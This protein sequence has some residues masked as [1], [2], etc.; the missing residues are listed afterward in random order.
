MI[1]SPQ[2]FENTYRS[3]LDDLIKLQINSKFNLSDLNASSIFY[4][5]LSNELASSG[6]SFPMEYLANLNNQFALCRFNGGANSGTNGSQL[7][8]M[9]N[10]NGLKNDKSFFINQMLDTK[11]GLNKTNSLIKM[12]DIESSNKQFLNNCNN[13]NN[14]NESIPCKHKIELIYLRRNVYKFLNNLMPYLTL[15]S[16]LDINLIDNSTQIDQMIDSLVNQFNNN[17]I[18]SSQWAI[19]LLIFSF[20]IFSIFIKSQ[21]KIFA[22]DSFNSTHCI[23]SKKFKN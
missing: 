17:T 23:H 21:L 15:T 13:K 11:N 1:P 6:K 3:N 8:F 2:S 22:W 16:G 7:D 20:F 14:N 5:L 18:N 4:S 19:F 10:S 9:A 12:D